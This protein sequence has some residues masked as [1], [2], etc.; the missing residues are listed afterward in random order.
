MNIFLNEHEHLE[1][2]KSP[3]FDK[4]QGPNNDTSHSDFVDGHVTSNMMLI[5]ALITH[6]T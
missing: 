3:L 1:F 6:I 5:Q 2:F 4:S